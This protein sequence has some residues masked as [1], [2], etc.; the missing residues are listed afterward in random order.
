MGKQGRVVVIGAGFA[1]LIAARE[2]EWAGFE[3][4]IFEARDRIGGRAWTDER[5]GLPLEMGATWVHWLQPFVWAEITR[6]A[7]GIHPSPEVEEAYWI[8]QGEVHHGTEADLDEKL[9]GAQEILFDGSREFFPYPFDPHFLLRDE[10]TPAELKQKFLDRDSGSV[11]DVL[12]ERGCSAEEIDLADAY[13]SAA[14]Q[15]ATADASPLMPMHWVSLAD[16]NGRLLDELTLKYKLDN[17]MRGLYQAIATDVQG[18]IHLNTPVRAVDS[19]EAG[20]RLRLDDGSEVTA[21]S[22][23]VTVPLGAMKTIDFTPALSDEQKALVQQGFQSKGF[24]I[25]IKLEGHHSFIAGAPSDFP[26]NLVKAEYF[27]E[28]DSTVLVG[29]GHDHT[30]M[31]LT[32]PALAQ[33]MLDNWQ[34]GL[35]VLGVAGHDWTA[36]EWSGQTWAT[37]RAGQFFAGWSLFGGEATGRVRFAGADWSPGWTGVCIDGAI[38][39]GLSTARGLIRDARA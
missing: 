23:I 13:W 24:K 2:L 8:S 33:A 37:L 22:V 28:D 5:L 20:V 9:S 10:D 4:E 16:H 27:P 11:L 12:R 38:E 17:G 7:Q 34:P 29:F 26:I 35:K 18:P 6:Y 1:G 14:F 3:V 36:D 32:D 30:E 39:S 21:D 15:G 19:D 25:W 31:S